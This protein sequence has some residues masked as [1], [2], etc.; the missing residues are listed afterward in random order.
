MIDFNRNMQTTDYYLYYSDKNNYSYYTFILVYYCTFVGQESLLWALEKYIK[1]NYLKIELNESSN[2][3]NIFQM[4][5]KIIL[6]ISFNI[7]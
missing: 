7:A 6:K 5:Q 2:V 1:N 3:Q 4:I